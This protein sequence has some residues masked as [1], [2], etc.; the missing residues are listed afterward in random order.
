MDL[1][2]RVQRAGGSVVAGADAPLDFVGISIHQNPRALVRHGFTPVEV[3]RTATTNA[4]EALGAA[5]TLGVIRPG[6]RADLPVVDG[7]PLRDV[8][9]AAR[10]EQVLVDGRHHTVRELLAPYAGLPR[11]PAPATAPEA[12]PVAGCCRSRPATLR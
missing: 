7:D 5:G 4:A 12:R 10:V 11:E 2:L 3:L 1:L 6:A 8:A 9:A